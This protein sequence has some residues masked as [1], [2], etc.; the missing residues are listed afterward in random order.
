VPGRD[1]QARQ[2]RGVDS[3]LTWAPTNIS[4][5]NAPEGLKRG[6][7]P[8]EGVSSS[9]LRWDLARGG[10]QPPSEA[11]PHPRGRPALERGG[12]SSVR[13]RAPRAKRSS[14]RGGRGQLSGGPLRPFRVV[15]P[16]VYLACVLGLFASL[17][18]AKVSGV[19]LV[20]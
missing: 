4:A 12:G 20:V 19:S 7:T 16:W 2:G 17:L 10:I 8:L 1:S 6:G 13:H 15:G 14:A 11:E 9:R 3:S 5:L 18:F